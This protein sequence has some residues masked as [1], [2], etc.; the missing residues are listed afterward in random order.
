MLPHH[1]GDALKS[2]DR[3]QRGDLDADHIRQTEDRVQG[4]VVVRHAAGGLIEIERDGGQLGTERLVV[5]DGVRPPR[6]R[7]QRV[8]TA[9]PGFA[10]HLH[11]IGAGDDELV[12]QRA[13]P[14][15]QHHPALLRREVG[16]A[17]RVRPDRH[18][19]DRLRRHPRRIGALRVFGDR[20]FAKRHRHRGHE[21]PF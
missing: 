3:V 4:G 5:R 17:S 9:R 20:G 10:R 8:G 12:R 1:G 19:R 7:Q 6:E 18:A 14:R 15:G 16:A 2:H 13:A 11:R 21:A